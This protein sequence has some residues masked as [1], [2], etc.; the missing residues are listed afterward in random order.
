[1]RNKTVDYCEDIEFIEF[2]PAWIDIV[3]AEQFQFILKM[4]KS[5]DINEYKDGVQLMLTF[6]TGLTYSEMSEECILPTARY[7]LAYADV[8]KE[9]NNKRK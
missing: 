8:N 5:D 9:S 6:I 3:K 1:M 7:I 4:L 2:N